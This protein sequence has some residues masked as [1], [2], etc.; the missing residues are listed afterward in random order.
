VCAQEGEAAKRTLDAA[1]DAAS[2]LLN[3]RVAIMK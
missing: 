2:A 3:L 1:L